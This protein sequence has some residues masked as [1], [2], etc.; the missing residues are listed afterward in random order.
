[1]DEINATYDLARMLTLPRGVLCV[2]GAQAFQIKTILAIV[3]RQHEGVEQ[4]TSY[5]LEVLGVEG[6]EGA[7]AGW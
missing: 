7:G 2:Y 4:T 5:I 3:L 1:M 6:E